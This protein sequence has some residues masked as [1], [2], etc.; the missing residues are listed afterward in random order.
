MKMVNLRDY[1]PHYTQDCFVEIPDE[2]ADAILSFERADA[3]RE[4]QVRRYKAYYSL[5]YGNG[6]EK[7][8]VFKGI[9]PEDHYEQKVTKQQLHA[10]IAALPDKQA[11]RVY[12]HFILGMRVTEIARA[13]GV[14]KSSITRSIQHAMRDL[15]I[16]L[17]KYQS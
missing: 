14:A 2:L 6:I 12:A 11:K 9:T 4:R 10:A 15:A 16:A 1:Y 8:I 5:D 3:A 13:E 7:A 17:K